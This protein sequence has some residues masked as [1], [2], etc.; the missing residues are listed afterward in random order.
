MEDA[1]GQPHLKDA[2]SAE[3]AEGKAAT[4]LGTPRPSQA[5]AED[6][7]AVTGSP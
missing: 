2:A 3:M 5:Q 1:L 7:D 4:A 6:D